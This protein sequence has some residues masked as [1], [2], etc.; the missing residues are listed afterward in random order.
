LTQNDSYKIEK[1]QNK[2]AD[3]CYNIFFFNIGS[4][5]I[6]KILATLNL[7]PLHSRW[8]HHD[9]LL[10]IDVFVNK[11][12]GRSILNTVGLLVSSKIT[13]D[14]STFTAPYW[15]KASPSAR[16]VTATNAVRSKVHIFYQHDI[17]PKYLNLSNFK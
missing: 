3:V 14:N 8:E 7:S 6:D 5:N 17:S 12:T 15:A 16:F 11:I 2:F 1:A 9:N 4:K 13:G 10:F